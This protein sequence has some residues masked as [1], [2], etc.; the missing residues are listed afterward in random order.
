MKTAKI[1]IEDCFYYCS[2]RDNVVILTGTL[3]VQY[4]ILTEVID[5]GL[6]I[7]ITS[8]TFLKRKDLFKEKRQLGQIIKSRSPADV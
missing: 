6:L 2:Y 3:K 7:V 8:S 4:I 5:C 1:Q